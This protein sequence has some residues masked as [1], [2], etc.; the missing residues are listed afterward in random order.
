MPT[1]RPFT[2]D[3]R[4]QFLE[5][6]AAK[7]MSIPTAAMAI[8]FTPTTVKRHLKDE[9]EFREALSEAEGIALGRVEDVVYEEA[10]KHHQAWAV[11]MWLTNR[12][13]RG[14]WVDE[15]DRGSGGGGNPMGS[16]ALIVGAMREVLTDGT[17]RDFA[18]AA[19]MEVPLPAIE[20]AS[21]EA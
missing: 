17:T 4:E 19:V 21:R 12:A 14:R 15:R 1:G 3:D 7:G 8:G 6:V 18:V 2:D 11:K 16:P 10:T 9:P 5:L 20:V 13:E